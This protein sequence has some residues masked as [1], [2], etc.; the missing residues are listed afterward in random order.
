MVD[1]EDLEQVLLRIEKSYDIKFAPLELS[2]IRTFAELSDAIISKIQLEEKD[3][4]TDQQAF[5]KLRKAILSVYGTD[6]DAITPSTDL[7]NVFPRASRRKRLNT[8]Q[9]LL[10]FKLN[11][12]RPRRWMTTTTA[13]LV[14]L[15]LAAFFV[16]WRYACSGLAIAIA[17][18]WVGKKTGIEFKDQTI[19]DLV[20]R[21]TAGN[22]L[23]SRR[24][25][26]SVNRK[27]IERKI[28]LLLKDELDLPRMPERGDII[29]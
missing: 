15:S 3:D 8:I 6:V 12:L 20:R 19:G 27:E 7:T 13:V 10:G 17:L 29:I 18:T 25:S 9:Q 4:C 22:Y 26:T 24:D 28:A 23:K 21:I 1:P 11:A 5:Y 2:H 14:I 16:D